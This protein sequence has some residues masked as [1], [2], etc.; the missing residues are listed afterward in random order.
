M[1]SRQEA[2]KI[3]KDRRKRS[4]ER[5]INLPNVA[6][7][8]IIDADISKMRDGNVS[9]D[10]E[11]QKRGIVLCGENGVRGWK[12][13]VAH[14]GKAGYGKGAARALRRRAGIFKASDCGTDSAGK[15]SA[16]G[17]TDPSRAGRADRRRQARQLQ[18]RVF[19]SAENL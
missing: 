17:S 13:D 7:C 6:L 5:R 1:K 16:T 19:V 15:R 18:L 9:A 14:R 11:E 3:E 10:G 8:G 2:K 12:E 4:Q